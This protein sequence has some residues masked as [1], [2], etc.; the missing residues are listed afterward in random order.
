[1]TACM[2][3]FPRFDLDVVANHNVEKSS[4]RI[5]TLCI[6]YI[7]LIHERMEGEW[8]ACIILRNSSVVLRCNNIAWRWC[9]T[10]KYLQYSCNDRTC[11]L[12]CITCA[13][14]NLYGSYVVPWAP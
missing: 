6:A 1:M 3:V 9:N 14:V 12:M 10:Q 7:R 11:T 2:G 4:L 5:E 8:G 13:R